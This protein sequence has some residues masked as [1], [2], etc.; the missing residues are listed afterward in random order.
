LPDSG[1]RFKIVMTN[2]NAC[3]FTIFKTA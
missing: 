3:I 2:S 1:S